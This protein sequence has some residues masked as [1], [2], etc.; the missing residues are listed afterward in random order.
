[1]SVSPTPAAEPAGPGLSTWRFEPTPRLSTYVTAL[2]A[3]P[4][5]HVHGELTGREGRTIPLGVFCRASL[6]EHLD[7]EAVLEVTEQGFGFFEDLFDLEYP[8]AK[9]DQLFVPEFNAGAMENAGAVTVTETYVFR[10]KPTE[11]AVERRALTILHELAHMWFGDLVTMR[12]WDDLWLN[13]SFAEY[14]ST[15]CQAA[16]T[17]W[18]PAWTTFLSAEKSWAYRQDQLATTHP[19]VADIRDLADVEVNFDGITYAKG[20]SVLKQLVHWVGEQA[21]DAGLRNYFKRYAWA[22]TS[23]ADLLAELAATSGRDLDAW[24]HQWLQ[25]AGVATFS[26]EVTAGADGRITAAAVVQHAPSA[27]P[28]LRM[29]RL[30]IGCYDLIDGRLA[31]THRVELDVDGQRTS[32]PDLVGLPQPALLLVNDDDLA[33]AKIRLDAPSMTTAIAHLDAFADSLPATLVWGA[34]WDMTRDAESDARAFAELVLGNIAGVRDPSVAQ[35]LLRQLTG[36]LTSYVAPEHRVATEELAGD[37]LADLLRA[38][39]PGGDTQ[40]LLARS[41]A[42]HACTPAQLDL[43]A[44]LLHGKATLP[45]FTVDTERRWE[46]LVALAAAGRAGE[47]EIDTELDRDDTA[48][49]RVHA[50]AARAAQPTPEAKAAA[51]ASVVDR[52]DLPN[53]VQ[54]AVI[55]GFNRAR[56]RALLEP[57]VEPY[58]AC[59]TRVWAERTNEM[60]SQIA[61]GLYPMLVEGEKALAATDDWLAGDG[62]KAEQALR[63][64][65]IEGR[66]GVV[67]AL[68]AQARDRAR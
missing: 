32:V 56:D 3:G 53:A 47:K 8:F 38:A 41:F 27:H 63:R 12:W 20:A 36:T 51:W 26:P 13:E 9:Y 29:H 25:T 17:R 5:H 67:R 33:Y 52:G 14:A 59:L 18:A 30:A 62:A 24:A 10:S 34:A 1:V 61:V 15:R 40:L 28:T 68:A 60:A 50:A 57:F 44:G 39:E 16:A 58:F 35:T 66:D 55:G 45:G 64:L 43:V 65:V 42:T 31:R 11:A 21:F 2:V 6:A 54:A 49:G 4:Y 23:L 37:R 46:L 22:N 19:I 7:A 48:S